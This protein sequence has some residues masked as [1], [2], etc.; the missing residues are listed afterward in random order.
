MTTQYRSCDLIPTAPT[1]IQHYYLPLLE[2]TRGEGLASLAEEVLFLK[3]KITIKP[4]I[5]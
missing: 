3:Y 1:E 5:H 4:F 2:F